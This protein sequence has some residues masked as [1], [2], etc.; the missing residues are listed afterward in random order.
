MKSTHA[1]HGD[2]GIQASL[3][4]GEALKRL[5]ER[6]DVKNELSVTLVPTGVGK[7]PNERFSFDPRANPR[8]ATI[9]LTVEKD[10]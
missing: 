4:V 9:L 10:E 7:S 1:G 5:V 8:I 6:G 3:D 2:F